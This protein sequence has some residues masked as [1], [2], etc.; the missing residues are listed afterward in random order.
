MYFSDRIFNESVLKKLL[1]LLGFMVVVY[2][3]INTGFSYLILIMGYVIVVVKKHLS[4]SS[5]GFSYCLFLML[6]GLSLDTR[7]MTVIDVIFSLVYPIYD[8]KN[9]KYFV[10]VF[11]LYIGFIFIDMG[12]LNFKANTIKELDVKEKQ[13]EMIKEHWTEDS[14]YKQ[15]LENTDISSFKLIK[16]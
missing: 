8:R 10:V 14:F 15:A 5:V 16:Q 3:C 1:Y 9:L 13:F 2:C 11:I 4:V 7:F 12:Y 6:T